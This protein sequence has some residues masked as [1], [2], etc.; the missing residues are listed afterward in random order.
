MAFNGISPEDFAHI[1]KLHSDGKW[2]FPIDRPKENHSV[3]HARIDLEQSKR[4]LKDHL[5]SL[6]APPF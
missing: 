4:D 2:P 6:E 3:N 5:E 1:K